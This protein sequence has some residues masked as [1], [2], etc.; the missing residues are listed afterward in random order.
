[1]WQ[2]LGRR[3]LWRRWVTASHGYWMGNTDIVYLT[4]PVLVRLLRWFPPTIIFSPES[5]R[6]RSS[7]HQNRT[8]WMSQNQV[9]VSVLLN[10]RLLLDALQNVLFDI[11]FI[12]F[13]SPWDVTGLGG[14]NLKFR[15]I[16]IW[17]L[18]RSGWG[19]YFALPVHCLGMFI[20]SL[21]AVLTW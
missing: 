10:S 12:L 18:N 17:A 20:L 19:R 14:M 3:T 7:A 8:S 16:T 2:P 6:P 4:L 11:T 1:M 9:T 15:R 21:L 5:H 13:I